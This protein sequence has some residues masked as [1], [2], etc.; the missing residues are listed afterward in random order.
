MQVKAKW[1]DIDRT[2]D[3]LFCWEDA[4]LLEMHL[5]LKAVLNF[6]GIWKDVWLVSSGEYR[7]VSSTTRFLIQNID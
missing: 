6:C 4:I 5:E 7:E 1:K 2:Q 3:T